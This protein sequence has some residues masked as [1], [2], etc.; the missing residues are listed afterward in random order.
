MS[1]IFNIKGEIKMAI[2]PYPEVAPAVIS[3]IIDLSTYVRTFPSTVGVIPIISEKGVDNELVKVN[4]QSFYEEFG[5]PDYLY[6]GKIGSQGMYVASNFLKASDSLYVIRCLPPNATYANLGIAVSRYY[7]YGENGS[8]DVSL[9]QFGDLTNERIANQKFKSIAGGVNEDGISYS[10]VT[11]VDAAYNASLTDE[12]LEAFDTT[13]EL[14][15]GTWPPDLAVLIV[16][17]GRGDWYN[18]FKISISAHSNP[19]KAAQHIYALNIYKKMS[20]TE[21]QITG[22]GSSESYSFTDRYELVYNFNVSFDP[23]FTDPTTSEKMFIRDVINNYCPELKC[24]A[25]VSICREACENNAD[26]DS[27]FT[28]SNSSIPMWGGSVGSLLEEEADNDNLFDDEETSVSENVITELLARAYRGKLP[29]VW[30]LPENSSYVAYVDEI[31][32]TEIYISIVLDGGYPDEAK[33]QARALAAEYRKDCVALL[34]NGDNYTTAQ[35]ISSREDDHNYNDM[36]VALYEPYSKIYDEFTGANIWL[37]PI[38]HLARIVPNTDNVG[39]PWTAPAGFDRATI[40]GIKELRFSPS[41][42]EQDDFY[43]HQ[44]NPIIKFNIGP[45]VFGQLTT[46]KKPSATQDLSIARLI[47]YI[48]RA[49]ENYCRYYIFSENNSR[50]WTNISRDIRIFLKD[51]QARR[52]LDSYQVHVGAS[53]YE[54]KTKQIHVDIELKPT[55][56]VERINLNFFIK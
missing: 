47:L 53:E 6:S 2:S 9:V 27:P 42:G 50:T 35:A 11:D 24:V 34:D 20:D 40:D 26:W 22:S 32:N 10:G 23:D 15:S 41:V 12:Y 18:Q 19:V 1:F 5:E 3:K 13:G 16:G 56:V 8:P 29:K 46:L 33:T 30:N 21:L 39:E 17:K 36:Y 45:T 49:L 43:I 54:L 25:D 48:K 4:G 31:L 44:I 38:Y 28:R 7:T 14:L 52:G 37:T 55:R 51:I